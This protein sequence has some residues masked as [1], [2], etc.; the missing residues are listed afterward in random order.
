[1]PSQCVAT[2]SQRKYSLAGDG[3]RFTKHRTVSLRVRPAIVRPQGLH[4]VSCSFSEDVE[5]GLRQCNGV[6]VLAL[7][8]GRWSS[9]R[10]RREF[11]HF[12]H[13]LY[14][15]AQVDRAVLR[16]CT[17]V[18]CVF[19]RFGDNPRIISGRLV[20]TSWPLIRPWSVQPIE[21]GPRSLFFSARSL[22]PSVWNAL[23]GC[24]GFDSI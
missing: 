12:S 11:N 22:E 23:L 15:C 19:W 20:P 18:S 5:V 24:L 2:W 16:Q 10:F 21:Y 6:P 13:F 1:M 17:W 7:Q 4:L 3:R 8:T 9:C 14:V